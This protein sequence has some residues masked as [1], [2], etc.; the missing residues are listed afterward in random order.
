MRKYKRALTWLVAIVLL[1]A[2]GAAAAWQFYF[3]PWQQFRANAHMI[4][5]AVERF[6]VDT[7]GSYPTHL[8]GVLVERGWLPAW[9]PSPFGPGT[10]HPIA[11]D[12][13]PVP[14]C[15]VYITGGPI[16]AD[17]SGNVISPADAKAQG[18]VYPMEVD[19]YAL[20]FYG[21]RHSRRYSGAA[22]SRATPAR[23]EP[24]SQ[25]WSEQLDYWNMINSQARI[26]WDRVALVLTAG[27]ELTP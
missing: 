22:A 10:M 19:H 27:E 11:P 25:D 16:V 6:A 15:F 20:V 8:D 1:L 12:A 13:P 2:I 26:D 5:L 9:P 7:Q 4:Q 14:G 23:P 21:P 17:A 24:A 3:R 18:F